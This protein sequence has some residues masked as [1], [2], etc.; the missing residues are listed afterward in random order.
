MIRYEFKQHGEFGNPFYRVTLGN[1][2]HGY[3]EYQDREW[4]AAIGKLGADDLLRLSHKVAQLN[5]NL[6]KQRMFWG[7]L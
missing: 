3:I 4:R 2:I 7:L 5:A 1:D 6:R